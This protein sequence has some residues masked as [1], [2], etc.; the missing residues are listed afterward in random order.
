MSDILGIPL[1]PLASL[2]RKLLWLLP[3]KVL[4]QL[5]HEAKRNEGTLDLHPK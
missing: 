2:R 3:T 1:G 5:L 4:Q